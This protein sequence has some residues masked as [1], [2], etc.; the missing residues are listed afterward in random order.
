[1]ATMTATV[2]RRPGIRTLLVLRNGQVVSR[3]VGAAP[4][5]ALRTWLDHA[6]AEP[7]P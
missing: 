7:V 3:Q 2:V 5:P 4:E 6:L 1:M